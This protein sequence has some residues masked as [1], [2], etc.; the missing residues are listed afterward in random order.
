[1]AS[2]DDNEQFDFVEQLPATKKDRFRYTKAEEVI[3]ALRD[4]YPQQQYAFLEQVG[5][6]TGFATNRHCDALV[7]GLWPSRG[8][9]II[10]F[11][12]KVRRSDWLLELSKPE[13]AEAIAQY[14]DRWYVAVG[15]EEIVKAGELPK[16]WGLFVP[17]KDGNMRCKVEAPLSDPEPVP[18]RSFLAAVARCVCAQVTDEKKLHASFAAGKKEGLEENSYRDSYN[19]LRKKVEQFTK[20]SGVSIDSYHGIEAIGRAVERVLHGDE[21][22]AQSRLRELHK[23]AINI[24]RFIGEQIK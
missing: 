22:H 3:Q 21:E 23:T 11:E 2:V 8:L 7:M 6:A 19:D 18:G 12:V 17:R 13:K 5:N 24:E 15:D 1:M 10:G 9:E 20:I 16:Q 4:R 14:C